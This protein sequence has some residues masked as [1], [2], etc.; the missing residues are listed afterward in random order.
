MKNIMTLICFAV[1]SF[2]TYA[3]TMVGAGQ[4]YTTL[5]AAFDDIN[6]GTL[7]G[8]IE[9]QITSSITETQLATLNASGSGFASYN[10]VVIYP[11]GAGYTIS[12]VSN[13][14]GL[15]ALNGADNV[16][17]DG[18]VNR[19]GTSADLTL[20]F[21]N[22]NPGSTII[23][24]NGARFN[25]VKY[26]NVNVSSPNGSHGAIR[27]SGNVDT[28]NAN[29]RNKISENNLSYNNPVGGLQLVIMLVNENAD[30]I[31]NNHFINFMF[32]YTVPLNGNSAGIR[33]INGCFNNVVKGNSF[34]QTANFQPIQSIN[35]CAI[36]SQ[37][38]VNPAFLPNHIIDNYIGGSAPQCGGAPLTIT[39]VNA[40]DKISF[41]GIF[42]QGGSLP[43][44]MSNN[45][46][47]NISIVNNKQDVSAFYGI[48][49]FSGYGN[50]HH[51][52]IG[53]PTGNGSI[54]LQNSTNSTENFGIY[55]SSNSFPNIHHNNI[56][57]ITCTNT[58]PI[59]YT[60]FTGIQKSGSGG[61]VMIENNLIGSEVTPASIQTNSI[62]E[63]W[64]ALKGIYLTNADS[65]LVN[66]N[67][68]S[69]LYNNCTKTDNA[70]E[71]G[72][73]GIHNTF[74]VNARI[75]NNTIKNLSCNS[76]SIGSIVGP[77]TG[78]YNAALNATLFQEIKG[79]KIYNLESTNTSAAN[80][81]V[82][83]IAM[84][85]FAGVFDKFK[86]ENNFIY[87]LVTNATG[88]LS[89]IEGIAIHNGHSI[90]INNV[91]TLGTTSRRAYGIHQYQTAGSN[92]VDLYHNTIYLD[93]ATSD[94][95]S[96]AYRKANNLPSGVYKN[97][98]FY[99]NK[100]NTT[101]MQLRHF[102]FITLSTFNP[103]SI[104]YNNYYAPNT[105]NGG[106]LGKFLGT[107]QTTLAQWQTST[108][109]DANSIE[110]NPLFS[111]A[112]GTQ[113][114]DYYPNASMPAAAI[115]GVN[116]D[117][118][119]NARTQFWMG[120]LESNVPLPI[121]YKSFT[122]QLQANHQVSLQWITLSEANASHFEIEKSVDAIHWTSINT[123][124]AKGHSQSE[125]HYEAIDNDVLNGQQYY[126]IK[127]F[128]L[129]GKYSYSNVE[130][131]MKTPTTEISFYPNPCMTT[132]NILL[133]DNTQTT[134]IEIYSMEGK[135]I[136]SK[137]TDDLSHQ[138][139]IHSLTN[140]TYMLRV[141]NNEKIMA[142]TFIKQ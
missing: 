109:Q 132:L 111:L 107:D 87:S 139:D 72:V 45:T 58:S 40:N 21:N 62:G 14:G 2:H 23:F 127:Q 82:K 30:T 54:S 116:T 80:V 130:K 13:T 47:S 124:K 119:Q 29:S 60:N 117:I 11:I 114:V 77:V 34:Y 3:Q 37:G 59:Y 113:I 27:F 135:K 50:I 36:Y 16:V 128:D 131:I 57:S 71:G 112:G 64:Q 7:T 4:T 122:A 32:Q 52:T 22:A 73:C 106:A 92:S 75:V 5:K 97:N 24:Q 81:L 55:I 141:F 133:S 101:G 123:M 25:Q 66:A 19:V 20:S 70:N 126:R 53:A 48:Y 140:G 42:A 39:S 33:M 85:V 108:T 35:T 86:I 63:S 44:E 115:V 99:N 18:R 61:Y 28:S 8:N 6:N 88:S 94:F 118:F 78:I 69:N 31:E 1:M 103:N 10:N 120:A 17:I 93:G 83:G 15:I 90:I 46:I 134:T 89:M 49:H 76:A 74:N 65:V 102:A 98:I 91:I 100:A 96:A 125:T 121:I 79:N 26:C 68:I 56:G 105:L 12:N 95:E 138:L 43:Y 104:D 84:N 41:I 142:T 137:K 9:L 129:D 51:N 136:M 38:P 67:I 110:L